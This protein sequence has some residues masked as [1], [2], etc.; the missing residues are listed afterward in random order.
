MIVRAIGSRK[1]PMNNRL[2]MPTHTSAMLSFPA[3]AVY[4]IYLQYTR[5]MLEDI[6]LAFW[7]LLPAALANAAPVFSAK[8]P[9]LKKLYAP[10]DGGLTW[11][12]QSSSDLFAM[13][14]AWA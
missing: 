4:F 13:A 9:A 10:I 11:R 5:H 12:G 2:A 8:I 14:S 7:F 6:L 1:A 3:T